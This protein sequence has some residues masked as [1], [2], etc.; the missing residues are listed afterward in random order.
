MNTH[1]LVSIV[2]VASD[3]LKGS[4]SVQLLKD[5]VVKVQEAINSPN[6][7]TQRAVETAVTQLTTA[8]EGAKSNS[9]SPGLRADLAE[10]RITDK[11][12]IT[13]ATELL[14]DGLREH[15][16]QL[17]ANGY[18]SVQTLDRLRKLQERVAALDTALEAS[19]KGLKDLGIKSEK[20]AEGDSIA[21]MTV[22]RS[23]VKDGLGRLIEELKFFDE[24]MQR[25][26]ECVDGT[27]QDP[28]VA[29]L[30]SSDFGIDVS[31][32]LDVAGVFALI[33]KGVK[34]ALDRISKFRK[35]KEDAEALGI[36][37]DTVES[38][39]KKSQEAMVAAVDEIEAEV[40][41]HCSL[42]DAGRVNELKTAIKF[43]INGLANRMERGFTFEVRTTLPA[44]A[45]DKAAKMGELVAGLTQV[46]FEPMAGPRLLALPEAEPD[47]DDAPETATAK[48]APKKK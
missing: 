2:G 22:P 26:S 19:R 34:L 48:R 28:P 4:Q 41:Q 32:T 11:V 44:E 13:P 33:V 39:T 38:L 5:L 42:D 24:L 7:N 6:E 47:K 31:T 3:D 35:L 9:L 36:D 20:L 37:S 17:F 29:S 40:F 45:S 46:R 25:L 14:G 15:L 30:R 12:S 10:L 27:S 16:L 1:R 43:K 21:G 18:T 8:L 23:E